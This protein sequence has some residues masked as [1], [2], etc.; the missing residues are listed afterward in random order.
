VLIVRF[1][2]KE[3]AEHRGGLSLFGARAG[4]YGRDPEI[5]IGL[6]E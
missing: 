2:V 6:A 4:R 5:R 3:E 1:E